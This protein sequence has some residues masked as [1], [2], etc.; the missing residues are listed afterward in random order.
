VTQIVHVRVFWRPLPGT[1]ADHPSATNAALDWYVL[2]DG[3]ERGQSFL[4]YS[5]AGFV[6]VGANSKGAK[7]KIRNAS[8]VLKD[9]RGQMT[10]PI[11]PARLTGAI[12]ATTN[13]SEVRS[14][15]AAVQQALHPEQEPSPQYSSTNS[16]PA[17]S[18]QGP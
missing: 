13:D 11:G 16:P 4:H 9:Q 7:F 10:D 2:S 18:H 14:Q 12:A 15:V 6:T 8:V 17:R 5:G 3:A 1:M